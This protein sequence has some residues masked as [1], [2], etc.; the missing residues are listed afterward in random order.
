MSVSNQLRAIDNGFKIVASF[1][2]LRDTPIIIGESDPEGCAACGVVDQPR[3]R[4]SQRHDVF[5]LH[6]RT[7]GADLRAGGR[8]QGEPA[9]LG[10][11]GVPVRGPA[12]LRRVP[13]SRD[14]RDRQAGPERLPHARTDARR[15]GHGREQR[16]A[17]AGA[18]ARYRRPRSA[19][20]QRARDPQRAHRLDPA[21][22]L[23]RRRPAGAAGG[24]R[25]ARGGRAGTHRWM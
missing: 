13:R 2:E 21:L 18:R 12:V 16:R 9:R 5:E 14:Q 4:V 11:V 8:P 20:R 17:A 10:D 23:S 22:E 6:G 19:G 15:P 3:E 1:P 7:A 25:S 24:G